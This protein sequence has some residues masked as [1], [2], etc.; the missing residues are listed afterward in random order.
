MFGLPLM[1]Q[2]VP[3]PEVVTPCS[4]PE[5][6]RSVC[7]LLPELRHPEG[8][9]T[10]EDVLGALR[11]LEKSEYGALETRHR[12]ALLRTV[13][14]AVGECVTVQQLLR[15]NLAKQAELQ[16]EAQAEW[17]EH[18]TRIRAAEVRLRLAA[19]TC[20]ASAAH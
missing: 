6:L 8:A 13:V 11:L 1:L 18:E 7:V 9:A 14:D 19:H 5:V 15:D 10:G 16:R 17:R 3:P 12:V 4:W 2:Q 20:T